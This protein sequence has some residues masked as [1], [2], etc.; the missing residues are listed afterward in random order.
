M[1]IKP[2]DRNQKL[3]GQSLLA[4][5]ALFAGSLFLGVVVMAGQGELWMGILVCWVSILTFAAIP[6]FFLN[7]VQ[8][9]VFPGKET[10]SRSILWGGVGAVLF[11]GMWVVSVNKYDDL[12]SLACFGPIIGAF[13]FFMGNVAESRIPLLALTFFAPAIAAYLQPFIGVTGANTVGLIIMLLAVGALFYLRITR[14]LPEMSRRRNKL[15]WARCPQC[16]HT[17]TVKNSDP[18]F[19]EQC[20]NCSWSWEKTGIDSADLP[21]FLL[22]KKDRN[23]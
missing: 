12:A 14:G 6:L 3:W 5:I 22:S 17:W 4:A 9:A 7:Y 8:K 10:I 2:G 23:D 11:G 20:P 21:T 15:T 13:G 16:G 19:E 1:S 18:A